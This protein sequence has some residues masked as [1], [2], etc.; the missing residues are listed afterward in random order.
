MCVCQSR[1]WKVFLLLP[2]LLLHK[3]PRGGEKRM[4]ERL[5]LSARGKWFPLLKA[6]EQ[7]AEVGSRISARSRRRPETTLEKQAAWALHLN[8]HKPCF[9]ENV[10]GLRPATFSP[11]KH[12]LYCLSRHQCLSLFF[13]FC[14]SWFSSVC[15]F[16]CFLLFFVPWLP[17]C[18]PTSM[19]LD[20]VE[21]QRRGR[22][23]K[24]WP[25]F[26]MG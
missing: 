23:A 13:Y 11:K 9:C 2:R 21:S 17:F 8:G 24:K 15:C 20:I 12:G 25:K 6:S 4:G 5:E 16:L 7:V 14:L 19:V 26:I 3:P 18:A 22:G 1:A 10:A